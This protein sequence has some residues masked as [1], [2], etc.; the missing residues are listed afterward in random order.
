[1]P[2]GKPSLGASSLPACDSHQTPAQRN[3]VVT[4]RRLSLK[5]TRPTSDA[6]AISG[7]D[8]R[9]LRENIVWEYVKAISRLIAEFST[10]QQKSKLNRT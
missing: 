3:A 2:L 9:L 10:P 7:R 6:A 8:W 4:A 5:A 1:M